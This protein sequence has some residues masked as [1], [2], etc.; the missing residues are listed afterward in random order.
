VTGA[1]IAWDP[2]AQR[3]VWRVAQPGP[4][5]AGTLAT[6]GDVVF[7]G[8]QQGRFQAFDA[9]NGRVLWSFQAQT[10]VIGSPISYGI[11]GVQYVL[12]VSGAGGGFAVST[13]FLDDKHPKPNGRVLA[14]R[15]GG[16]AKLPEFTPPALGKA[17]APGDRFTSAQVIAGGRIFET[18]CAWCHGG[19]AVSGGVLPDLRRSPMLA[20][21]D[22]WRSVVID[23]VLADRGM[24]SFSRSMDA[25]QAEAVRA[26]VASLSQAL[27]KNEAGN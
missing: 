22:A 7:E 12:V 11:D 18:T 16:T 23:G 14:F 24:V 21:R 27:A 1:L 19:G 26:Y 6:A 13:P 20:S 8:N 25:S 17:T 5:S 2:V 15:L 4:S 10:A 3:E 9:R